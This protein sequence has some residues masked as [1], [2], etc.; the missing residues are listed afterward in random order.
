[1]GLPLSLVFSPD[2]EIFQ[3]TSGARSG[4]SSDRA[5]NVI[6]LEEMEFEC[7][8]S[9]HSSCDDRSYNELLDVVTCAGKRD[10]QTIKITQQISVR[11]PRGGTRMTNFTKSWSKNK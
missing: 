5:E 4:I 7:S 9:E 8:D 6:S 3:P 10:H 11:W 1:M 2:R